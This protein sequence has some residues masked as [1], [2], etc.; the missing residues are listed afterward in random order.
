VPVRAIAIYVWVVVGLNALAWLGRIVPGLGQTDPAF[1]AGTG[2]PTNPIFVQ[3]LVF[4]LPLMA[5][6]AWWLFRERD[7]GYVVIGAML[8]TWLLEAVTVAVDQWVGHHA[9][10]GS[11]VASSAGAVLF[12]AMAVI[13]MVP[14]VAFYR[15]VRS[16]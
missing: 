3:D 4:W 12:G 10:P 15:R 14:L 2:L 16:G 1:L 5:L 6:A 11:N 9:D 13:G 8:V 7:W